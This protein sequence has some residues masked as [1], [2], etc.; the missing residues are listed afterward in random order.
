MRTVLTVLTLVAALLA[1]VPAE[2]A[3]RG[4]VRASADI[5]VRSSPGGGYETIGVLREGVE[6]RLR[7]CTRDADWCLFLGRDG[8]PAGW[9]RGSY[10]VGAAAKLH[11]MPN[12][13]LTFDPLDPLDLCNDGE[14]GYHGLA[15][16]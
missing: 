2:A 9:V 4:T 12:R 13:F 16:R 6:V 1:A 11:A 3:S 5:P 15:C 10:L 8:R 7:H 14:A